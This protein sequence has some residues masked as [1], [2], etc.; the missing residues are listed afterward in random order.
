ME[1]AY[2]ALID[3]YAR[4]R[5]IFL[6]LDRSALAVVNPSVPEAHLI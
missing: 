2:P 6:D 1:P 3:D 4:F 5:C